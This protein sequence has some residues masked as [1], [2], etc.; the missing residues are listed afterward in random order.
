MD[1]LTKGHF[2]KFR[3]PVYAL[4]VNLPPQVSSNTETHL[5]K[6]QEKG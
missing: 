3:F 1:R 6:T 2:T 5:G 4:T